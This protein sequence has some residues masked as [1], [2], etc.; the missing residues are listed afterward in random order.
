MT[1]IKSIDVVLW[2]NISLCSSNQIATYDKI[3]EV[4]DDKWNSKLKLNA[5]NEVLFCKESL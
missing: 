4:E 5:I 1:G 3:D 2:V